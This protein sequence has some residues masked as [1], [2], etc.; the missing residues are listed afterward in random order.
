MKLHFKVQK[1]KKQP[2]AQIKPIL[3]VSLNKYLH[4][5]IKISTKYTTYKIISNSVK[6]M[7]IFNC[8]VNYLTMMLKFVVKKLYKLTKIIG[9]MKV[10]F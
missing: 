9:P 10:N 1:G 7:E 2:E 4:F 5:Y 3:Q 8:C 6:S